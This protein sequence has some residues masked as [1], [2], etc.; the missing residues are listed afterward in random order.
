MATHF[1]L[2]SPERGWPPFIDWLRKHELDP[3][4]VRAI[5]VNEVSAVATLKVRDADGRVIVDG[6]EIRTRTEPIGLLSDPPL[7]PSR[8]AV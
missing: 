8:S 7:H 3:G 4:D 6:D 1:D 2:T 5:T